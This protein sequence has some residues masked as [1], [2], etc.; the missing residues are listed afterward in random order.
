VSS[1][2]EPL[3]ASTAPAVDPVAAPPEPSPAAPRR[4]LLWVTL[5]VAAVVVLVDQVTKW[6]AVSHLTP[7]VPVQVVGDLLRLNLTENSGA[8]FSLGAGF[9]VIFTAIA[10]TVAVVIVRTASRLGSVAWAVALGGLL[11]GALGNLVDRLTR[12]PGIGRGYVVDFLQLPHW[13]VFNCA[14]MAIVGSA[15]LMVGLALFG[16]DLD[17]SRG[18]SAGE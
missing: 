14:D 16:V 7:G 11:G 5:A 3:E 13:A 6:L 18:R 10:I 12:A 9:T 15:V 4:N 8:A 17:G 1:P 2:Q